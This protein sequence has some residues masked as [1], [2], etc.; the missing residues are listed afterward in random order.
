MLVS[1][2]VAAD[3]QVLVREQRGHL[4]DQFVDEGVDGF[5]GRVERRVVD[6][7]GMD[8]L[9]G[10]GRAGEFGI[11]DHPGRAMAGHVEL[12]DDADAAVA[13]VS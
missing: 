13:G 6:A 4:A 2:L 1:D 12:G 7:E 11:A 9:V 5:V 3:V 8:D 10:A